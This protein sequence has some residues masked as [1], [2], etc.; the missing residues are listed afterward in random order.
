MFVDSARA[1]DVEVRRRAAIAYARGTGALSFTTAL[2]VWGLWEDEETVHVTVPRSSAFRSR[3]WVMMHRPRAELD[4]VT[5]QAFSVTRLDQ[6]LVD[7]WSIL[8][9]A[10][11]REPV[12]RAI[13]ER[14]TT[15]GRVRV[16]LDGARRLNGLHEFRQLVRLLAQGCRSEL[17]IWGHDNVFTG[18]GMPRFARQFPIT[19]GGRTV[20][21]DV[22]A[23]PERVDFELDGFSTHGDPRQR[24]ADLRRD[25]ALAAQGILVVRFTRRRLLSEPIAVRTEILA[26]LCARQRP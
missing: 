16:A 10:R 8:P 24:E 19:L 5:R 15:V 2:A 21:L 22:F 26:I 23:E 14:M 3:A 9:S 11:R 20:Y 13:N 12:I 1:A 7:A 18:P 4:A 25:A 6:T 17:E